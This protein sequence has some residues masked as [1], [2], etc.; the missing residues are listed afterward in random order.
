[1]RSVTASAGRAG[2]KYLNPDTHKEDKNGY[3]KAFET[4]FGLVH[5]ELLELEKN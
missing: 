3:V 4:K 1:M 2:N 5:N